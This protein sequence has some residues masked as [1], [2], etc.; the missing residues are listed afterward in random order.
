MHSMFQSS[1]LLLAGSLMLHFGAQDHRTGDAPAADV[2]RDEV[3]GSI[4]H[5]RVWCGSESPD[6][7]R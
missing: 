7:Q 2:V 5:G 6:L 1:G 4:N 3:P